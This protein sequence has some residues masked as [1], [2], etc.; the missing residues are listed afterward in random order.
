MDLLQSS[1]TG[2]IRGE[3]PLLCTERAGYNENQKH[4]EFFRENI[5]GFVLYVTVHCRMPGVV[6]SAYLLGISMGWIAFHGNKFQRQ[7]LKREPGQR[8]LLDQTSRKIL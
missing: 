3:H 7:K 1:C 8:K 2:Y 4:R 5:P 6:L